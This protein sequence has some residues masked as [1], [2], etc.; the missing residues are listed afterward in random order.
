MDE[1]YTLWNQY[2]FKNVRKNFPQK[3]ELIKPFLSGFE[4]VRGA[5]A[6]TC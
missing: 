6:G 2:I 5:K 1:V 4:L 3:F